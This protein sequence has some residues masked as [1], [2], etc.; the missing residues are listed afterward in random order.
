VLAAGFTNVN[1]AIDH[2]HVRGGQ[3]RVPRAEQFAAAAGAQVFPSIGVWFCHA[4][5]SIIPKLLRLG[6]SFWPAVPTT[7]ER[8][9]GSLVIDCCVLL[10]VTA[11]K[12]QLYSAR[13]RLSQRRYHSL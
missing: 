4:S 8:T 12:V 5:S 7:S 11:W 6:E 1:D 2:Q 3:L 10:K 13:A 9:A